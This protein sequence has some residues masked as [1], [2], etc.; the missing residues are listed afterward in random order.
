MTTERD[1]LHSL[2]DHLSSMVAYWDSSLHCR[3]ANRAYESWFGIPAEKVVGVT[4][5]GSPR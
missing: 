1:L 2:I 5:S 3:F 4:L